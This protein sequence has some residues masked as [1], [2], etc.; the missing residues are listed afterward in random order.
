M[1]LVYSYLAMLIFANL[2]FPFYNENE[3]SGFTAIAYDTRGSD[4]FVIILGIAIFTYYTVFSDQYEK[5]LDSGNDDESYT[6]FS[7][8]LSVMLFPRVIRRGKGIS[9]ILTLLAII[10]L[11]IFTLMNKYQDFQDKLTRRV[12]CSIQGFIIGAL[13]KQG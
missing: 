9:V 5:D 3:A 8:I 7:I 13:L 6:L 11:Y 12:V 4:I 10:L 2:I 1:G